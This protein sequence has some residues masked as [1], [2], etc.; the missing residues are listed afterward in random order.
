MQHVSL[1]ATAEG[2]WIPSDSAAL[3][4]LLGDPAPDFDPVGFVVRNL[5]FVQ[6][7]L[8]ADNFAQITLFPKRVAM[9]ALRAVQQRIL[10]GPVRVFRLDYLDDETKRWTQELAMNPREAIGRLNR[11][12]GAY[13]E[14]PAAPGYDMEPL[15]LGAVMA[16]ECHPAHPLLRKWRSAFHHFDDGVMP[17][18]AKNGLASHSM[19]IGVDPKHPDPT[20]RFI[21]EGYSVYGGDFFLRAVGHKV[22]DQPDKRYGEWV[23]ASATFAASTVTGLSSTISN[24]HPESKSA[25]PLPPPPR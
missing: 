7:E 14:G 2:E 21:G 9:P 24:C 11:L 19:V 16:D 20:F 12:C 6:Y 22:A 1:L 17:F 18:L 10:D 8:F 23:A 3:L 5:G 13:A 4:D 25:P 15:D